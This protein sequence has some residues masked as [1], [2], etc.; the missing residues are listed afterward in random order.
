MIVGKAT[1]NASAFARDQ[2]GTV[3][4]V[5]AVALTALLG[6]A[7]LVAEY[8]NGLVAQTRNQRIADSAAYAAAVYYGANLSAPNALATATARAQSVGAMNGLPASSVTLQ[9]V[10]SPLNASNQA[11]YVQVSS[12]ET[13]LL[14]PILGAG[15]TLT[16]N[17]RSYAQFGP[18]AAACIVS[19]SSTVGIV[20]SGG[21]SLSAPSCSVATNA[22]E[23]VPCGATLSAMTVSYNTS[24]PV[25]PC[26]NIRGSIFKQP[27]TDPLAT[28]SGVL[29]AEARQPVV[30]AMTAPSAPSV[31]APTG[32]VP[33]SFN[34]GYYPTTTQ[35][36]GS[37]TA[38]YGGVWTVSCPSGF[39]AVN[40]V[41]PSGMSVNFN[42]SGPST[43]IYVFTSSFA[44]GGTT[45]FGPGTYYFP[46]SLALAG[47]NT[48]GAGN[49]Y[50][51]SSLTATGG[52]ATTFGSGNYVFAQ[53]I[54]TQ[55]GTS[56]T[57]GSGAF[58]FGKNASSCNGGG[59]YSICHTGSSLTFG[60]A[61]VFTMSNGVYVAGGSTLTMGMGY[62]TNSFKF[63]PS[64]DG[65]A[66][67]SGGGATVEFGDVSG[68]NGVFQA[69]GNV[70]LANG[71]ACVV[72]SA[73]AQHDIQGWFSTTGGTVLGS[74]VYTIS[75]YFAAGANYGGSVSCDNQGMV[76]VQGTGV[77]IVVGQAMMG[78]NCNNYG[79]CVGSGYNPF[80]LTAP[81]TGPTANLVVVGPQSGTAVGALFTGGAGNTTLSGAFYIPTGQFGMSGGAIIGSGTG[82]CLQ[83]VALNVSM[84][85]GSAVGSN[86]VM[87]TGVAGVTFVK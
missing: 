78:G 76:G 72:L 41:L 18:T 83:I 62:A 75:Q 12:S 79:F 23:T 2:R 39:Y 37:C 84:S 28:N 10:T 71:G 25:V 27:T 21:V 77:T 9:L 31:T 49:Y 60:G 45:V 63:G 70:N 65:N 22:T 17:A 42:P 56:T 81:T 29:A 86:C 82:Q 26:S 34:L 68:G 7:S 33:V 64:T 1:S 57:F 46:N 80:T 36:S 55:G 47:T 4:I 20:F 24:A 43:S 74:G 48:F 11:I 52:A 69:V 61:S 50:F 85:G 53:G 5:S 30:S 59:T 44:T 51:G 16:S 6:F 8:G 66:I 13:L 19:L 73:A 54:V 15:K 87:S 35:T 58:S 38:T 40:L 67:F 3:S 14:A 32:G